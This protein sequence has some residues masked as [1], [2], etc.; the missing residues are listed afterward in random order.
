MGIDAPEL[1]RCRKLNQ[2]E[3]ETR[4][5]AHFLIQLARQ[6][7]T[8]LSSIAPVSTPVTLLLEAKNMIDVYGRTLAYVYTSGERSLNE[9]M[10]TEGYAKPFNKH[11]CNSLSEYQKLNTFAK[12]NKRGL[13]QA[14]NT[15]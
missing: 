14:T 4:L 1:K 6:S 12:V 13:Y 9:M 10:I 15:F 11:Y 7:F 5:A 8:Y 3:R 2:D